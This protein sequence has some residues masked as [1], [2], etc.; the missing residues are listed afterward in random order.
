[1]TNAMVKIHHLTKRYKNTK[2]LALKGI[3]LTI[4]HGDF[5]GL[6]GPNGSGKT[7][8]ISI[9]CGLI[10][11]SAGDVSIGGYPLN[12]SLSTIKQLIGLV[13]QEI[14]L[15]PTLTLRENLTLFAKLY[16]LSSKTMKNNIEKCLHISE[17]SAVLDRSIQTY[18]G[19]MKRRANL[20]VGLVHDP[21]LLLLDEPTVNVDPQSRN[22]L[23]ESL[24]RL[25]QQGTTILYTTHYLEEVEALCNRIAI[26]NEGVMIASD[27]VEALKSAHPTAH[28]LG[29]I[30]LTLTGKHLR[31]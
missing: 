18:S 26:L 25:N 15:Y 16:G 27:T 21:K 4:Y 10:R 22:M 11:P 24:R 19:G 13:P 12:Q 30:F 20:A 9:L 28:N 17:L 5:F 2:T 1:M 7:T 14:S 23:F 8:L 3:D 29:D 31:D 6:L